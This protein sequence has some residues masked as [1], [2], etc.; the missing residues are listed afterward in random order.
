VLE[1]LLVDHDRRRVGLRVVVA[2]RLDEAAIARR[3]LV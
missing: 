2:D 3:A 1:A